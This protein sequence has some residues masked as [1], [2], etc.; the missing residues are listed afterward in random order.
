MCKTIQ[1]S[2][3]SSSACRQEPPVHHQPMTSVHTIG[4]VISFHMLKPFQSAPSHHIPHGRETPKGSNVKKFQAEIGGCVASLLPLSK[5]TK[6]A[7]EL[8]G[9]S[10]LKNQQWIHM[11]AIAFCDKRRNAKPTRHVSE[12]DRDNDY[13][14]SRKGLKKRHKERQI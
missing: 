2:A 5:L 11:S 3:R 7:Q 13:Y 8:L 9:E 6:T 10:K 12:E 1:C 14:K 4:I